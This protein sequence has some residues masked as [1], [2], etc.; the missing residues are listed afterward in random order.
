MKTILKIWSLAVVL[1][2]GVSACEKVDN[3]PSRLNGL[4]TRLSASSDFVAPTAADSNKSVISFNWS[5]PD[6]ATDSASVK[7]VFEI[8]SAGRN[9]RQANVRTISGALGTSFIAKELNSI[10]LNWGF[11]FNKTYDL[12]ARVIASYANNNDQ[13]ISNTVRIKAT[14]YK[15]PPRVVL[16]ATGRLFIV[17]SA[18]EGDWATPIVIPRQ[19]FS[20]LDET[21]FGGVFYLLGGEQYL[22]LPQ[23]TNYDKK[24]AVANNSLPGLSAGGAFGLELNDNFPAPAADGWY[25]VTMDFQTGRFAVVPYVTTPHPAGI[26][27]QLVFVGDAQGWSNTASNPLRFT[28]RNS[29]E[30]TLNVTI[31]GGG[32]YLLLPVPGS[33][34]TKFGVDDN[35]LEA[36]KMGGTLKREGANLKNPAP[37]RYRIDVNFYDLSYKLTLLP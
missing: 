12:E 14:T 19:E 8:D 33:W 15:I 13:R 32:E 6:F 22:V 26:P 3:F 1:L 37:G 34:A 25:R 27:Q 2:A 11:D 30:Y 17:G 20:R 24:Y 21:T 29:T 23:N 5:Y 4:A 16:P 28:R 31:S 9:F 35:M 18:T 10:M 7:Y 36:A